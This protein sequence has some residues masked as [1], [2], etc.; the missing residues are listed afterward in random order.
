MPVIYLMTR[1][2]SGLSPLHFLAL[3]PEERVR[4]REEETSEVPGRAE[5][6]ASWASSALAS[7]AGQ[8]GRGGRASRAGGRAPGRSAPGLPCRR[9]RQREGGAGGERGGEG[10]RRPRPPQA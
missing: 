6:A 9:A 2:F 5:I 4:A 3:G 1:G 8:R 7:P 10:W